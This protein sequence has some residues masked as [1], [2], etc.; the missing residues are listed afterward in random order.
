MIWCQIQ[1]QT[2]EALNANAYLRLKIENLK[3]KMQGINENQTYHVV[4]ANA[5]LRYQHL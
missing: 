1:Y 4:N 2:L 3:E 5:Y